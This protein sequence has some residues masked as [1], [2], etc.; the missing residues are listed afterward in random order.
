MKVLTSRLDADR[1]DDLAAVG[2]Q[3]AALVGHR[4]LR[5]PLAQPVHRPRRRAPPPRVLALAA[6]A[7]DVVVSRVHR[8]EQLADLLRRVLQ[9]GV[10]RDDALA[11]AALETGDDRDVLA[12]VGVEQH[13]PGDV[14]PALELLAQQRR[15]AVAAAVVDEDDLVG[16]RQRVERRVEAREQR[17]QAGLLVV[18]RNHDRQVGVPHGPFHWP[19]RSARQRRAAAMIAAVAAQTRSTSA[20]VSAACS[21]S[22]T[23]SRAMRSVTGKSP[24][25]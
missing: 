4:D 6:H 18:D 5:E 7:A 15:R 17:R 10:E 9:V 25:P 12:V 24:S 3:H 20:A 8:R 1:R 19:K 2:A 21:G 22:V 14:G 16:P 11:A 13:D 23:V